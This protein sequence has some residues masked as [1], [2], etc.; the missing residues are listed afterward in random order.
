M[1]SFYQSKIFFMEPDIKLNGTSIKVADEA[2]FTGLVFERRLAFRAHV[3]YLK[4]VCDRDFNVL[5]VVGH[6]DCGV[7]KVILCVFIV[8]YYVLSWINGCIV[9]GSARQVGTENIGCS[10][11]CTFT[12]LWGSSYSSFLPCAKSLRV[13]E[14]NLSISLMFETCN[15]LCIKTPF[16]MANIDR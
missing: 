6:T 2:K 8:H 10:S 7:D 16:C 12:H 14:I 11:P 15:E 9:S 4:S 1:C 5:R 13:S 3:K